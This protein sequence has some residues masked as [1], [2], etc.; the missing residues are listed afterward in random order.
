MRYF[1]SLSFCGANYRGWQI[2]QNAISVQETIEKS[3]STLLREKISITGAGRT[4]ASVNA[5]NYIAHFDSD[6]Q[7]IFKEHDKFLYKMNAIL[8]YDI[9]INDV[10]SMHENAHA[11]FDAT[12][13]TY[14]YFIHFHKDPFL[15]NSSFQYKFDL[16]I[17]AMNKAASFLIGR[18]DFSCFEKVNGG[19][20]NS[21]CTLYEAHWDIVNKEAPGSPKSSIAIN[22]NQIVFT[23]RAN[24]FLRNMVRAIVGSLLEIGRGRK[25]PEWII[26]VINS[27][28]RCLAGQSVPGYALFLT[29]ITY[30]YQLCK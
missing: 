3:L 2:Q 23:V 7:F 15:Q 6:S 10:F 22:N 18:K 21:I 8:P 1:L 28:D 27:K 16:D 30:P 14:Q 17:D 5:I 11:R 24:R 25:N 26:D 19:N 29:K 9:V 12:S 13:R 20:T 4:D